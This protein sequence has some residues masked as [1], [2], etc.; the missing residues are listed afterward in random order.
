MFTDVSDPENPQ[1]LG[2][3]K[4]ADNGSTHGMTIDDRYA[5]ACAT[6]S[7]SKQGVGSNH[8]IV[9]VDYQDPRRR[10][11][12]QRRRFRRHIIHARYG[13]CATPRLKVLISDRLPSR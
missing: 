3:Y 6:T 13:T 4:T 2:F 9:I 8:H 1:Q 10:S 12:A 7:Q 11:L 5:Y